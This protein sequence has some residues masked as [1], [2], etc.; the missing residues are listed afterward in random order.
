MALKFI[1]H[2]G[3][4]FVKVICD[5]CGGEFHQKDTVRVNNKYNTQHGL[6]VCF[7]DFDQINEQ[8]LPNT[9]IDRPIS[10]PETLRPERPPTFE[11]N[12]NDDRLPGPPRAPFAQANPITDTIDL[13]WQ[14]PED[15]GSSVIIGYVIERATPQLSTYR[16]VTP[17]TNSA[18]TYFNDTSANVSIEYSYKVAAINGFG[19]GP[20]SEEFFWPTVNVPWMDLNY[21]VVSGTLEVITTSDTLYGIR[22][23]HV[24]AGVQ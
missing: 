22:V 12:L 2:P 19:T 20:Y 15:Q 1:K 8:V 21:L 23:N 9:H 11:A 5:V 3:R 4:G 17:N 6:V 24:N 10:S 18:A 13:L 14:G 7:K 16:V